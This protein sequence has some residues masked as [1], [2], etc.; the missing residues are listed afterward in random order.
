MEKE[1]YG[2]MYNIEDFYWW[3]VG[4]RD[5]VYSTIEKYNKKNNILRILDA[6]CGT[7]KILE[8]ISRHK[9]Y[10]IDFS[11]EAINYCKLRKL[12]N[13]LRASISEI[14]FRNSSFNFVISLDVLYHAGIS[15]DQQT[16][17]E[18]Y[19]V[20][21]NDG[22]LL[23]NLPAYNF[24]QSRHDKAIHTKRRYVLKDLKDKVERAGFVVEKITYRNIILFPI[25]VMKR[26]MEKI[27]PTES[28]SSDLKPMPELINRLFTFLLL[29]ENKFINLGVFLPFGLSVFCIARKKENFGH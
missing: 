22:I 3:Y 2:V 26:I 23:L 12:N 10:G 20:M 25:A 4:L 13:L 27:I 19:R 29:I 11:E 16:L 15:N 17:S 14:P 28:T 8:G 18:L 1:E 7:G 21:D 9:F 6:G 24:L 5:L